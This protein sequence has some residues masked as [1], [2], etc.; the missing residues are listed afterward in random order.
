M[1]MSRFSKEDD[2]IKKRVE[3]VVQAAL[4]AVR[5]RSLVES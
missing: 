1:A 2:V 3:T 4:Y 5:V